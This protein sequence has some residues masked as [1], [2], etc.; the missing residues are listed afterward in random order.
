LPEVIGW[1]GVRPV[2][3]HCYVR[4]V[5]WADTSGFGTRRLRTWGGTT[6]EQG[7]NM[8]ALKTVLD[9]SIATVLEGVIHYQEQKAKEVPMQEPN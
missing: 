8:N 5:D 2:Q 6:K 7:I 1:T 4:A 9:T 3:L